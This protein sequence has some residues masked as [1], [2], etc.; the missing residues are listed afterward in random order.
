MQTVS[1][2]ISVSGSARTRAHT[3]SGDI[4]LA[5]LLGALDVSTVSGTIAITQAEDSLAIESVS[6]DVAVDD[7]PKGI[8]AHTVSGEPI[9]RTMAPAVT[10]IPACWIVTSPP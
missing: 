7:A 1:G 10:S 4:D 6:G 5:R 2:D 8:Q 9:H 3:I